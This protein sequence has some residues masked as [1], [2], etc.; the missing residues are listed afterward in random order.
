[1]KNA[2]TKCTPIEPIVE[3]CA[4]FSVVAI[5]V[6]F[7]TFIV[8]M[9]GT[10]DELADCRCSS[11]QAAFSCDTMAQKYGL[12]SRSVCR[13]RARA[14]F[15]NGWGSGLMRRGLEMAVGMLALGITVVYLRMRPNADKAW[16][17]TPYAEVPPDLTATTSS[18][19]VAP[20]EE[21]DGSARARL[22]QA[23]TTTAQ[24]RS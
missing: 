16:M 12:C 9:W 13:L 22:L 20:T 6:V 5:R 18:A 11:T 23:G 14:R 10:H 21:A 17:P 24:G 2:V 7:P 19:S 1:M 4:L 15:W 3:F 8:L